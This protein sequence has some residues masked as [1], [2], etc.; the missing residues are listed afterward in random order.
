MGIDSRKLLNTA[1]TWYAAVPVMLRMQ[2]PTS[3]AASLD[4]LTTDKVLLLDGLL[5]HIQHLVYWL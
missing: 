3:L 4:I 1:S 5:S 2:L